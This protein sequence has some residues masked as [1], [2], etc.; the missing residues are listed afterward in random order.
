MGY[1]SSKES[2]YEDQEDNI[3]GEKKRKLV[4]YAKRKF[5]WERTRLT[6]I[7]AK[8]GKAHRNNLTPHARTMAKPRGS[9]GMSG[10]AVPDG[11]AWA[12]RQQVSTDRYMTIIGDPLV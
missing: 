2:E 5:S 1:M 8:L 4:G 3:T 11:S 10:R 6:S 12:V 7:K 9:G